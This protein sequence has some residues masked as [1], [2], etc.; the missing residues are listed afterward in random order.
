MSTLAYV[1]SKT[2]S[3][4]NRD[5]SSRLP[6]P[7]P[8]DP[9]MAPLPIAS[10][11]VPPS[12]DPYLIVRHAHT[13]A[14]IDTKSKPDEAPSETKELQ[15]LAARTTPPSSDH[16][17]TSSDPTPVSPLTD[18]EFEAS[19]PSDTRI[20]SS[21]STAPSN[22]TTLLSPNY[23]LIQ[24]S[25]TLTLSRPLYYRRNARMGTFEPI[26]D[27]KT[28]DDESKAEG[29][30]S[31][32]EDSEDEGPDSEGE[33]AAPEGQRRALEIAK[34]IA[35]STFEIGQSS[36]SVPHQQV[37]DETPTYWI[38][39]RTSWINPKDG[40]VYLDIEIDPLSCAPVQTSTSP[41][42]H[43][44]GVQ[45]ELYGSILHHHTQR[46]DT[47]SSTLLKGH[48]WDITDLFNRSRAVRKEIRF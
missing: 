14:T 40:T 31:G 19:E 24:T 37:A 28:E 15:P 30:D 44:V 32:S 23:P 39:A 17:P 33:K 1:D 12:N 6:I 29:A 47:L 43:P 46:F 20:T 11:P 36:R 7:L 22:S 25:P 26:L 2:I 5:R 10:S 18:E 4:T 35:P 27:T 34:E 13:P 41:N 42:G 16:T 3:Q 48:G 21:H 45:L 9:Y 38:P 8:D